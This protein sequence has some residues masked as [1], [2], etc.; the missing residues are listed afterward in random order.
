LVAG[1]DGLGRFEGI[2]VFVPRAAPGDRLR[3]R[4]VERHPDYGR[5]E[6]VEIL[7]PGAERRDPPC[8][9]FARCG[10]CDLQHLGDD[11]Q[12]RFKAEATLE[13]LARLGGIGAL[14][15]EGG[16]RIMRGDA[17][18]YRLRAQLHVEQGDGETRVGY[19]ARASN[20]LVPVHEC[21]VLA[22]ALENLVRALPRAL[23]PSHAPR[24]L[25]LAAG[26]DGALSAAP[27]VEGLPRGEVV[28]HA[29]GFAYAF[30]ARCFFQGHRGL[31]DPLVEI[32][33]GEER[34][35][36]AFDLFSGV[37]MFSLP[38]AARYERVV[39]VESDAVA[40][41]YART[42]ARR[43]RVENAEFVQ[44]GVDDWI[45]ELPRGADRVLVDPPRG[46][47]SA[48]TRRILVDRAPRRITYVSC[49][50]AALAR[51]L[52]EILTAYLPRALALID[53]F[54]QTGH[55]ETVVQLEAR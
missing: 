1:G 52:R 49:H 34:G 19:H 27:V 21:R 48:A 6:I 47:L 42:N 17:W 51:D 18:G 32:A 14:A 37:G 38:L 22:P 44:R 33:V 43:N 45:R 36:A 7:A 54:P 15:P 31:L 25:D 28:F 11:A 46:G 9:H 4:L 8:P 29:A 12:V 20:D 2:P 13:T 55:M 30:D 24:R 3:V 39:G 50:A 5:G 40:M 16:L 35:A 10:G 23:P 26:E 53:L 41:R